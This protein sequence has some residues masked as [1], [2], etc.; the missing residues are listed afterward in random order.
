MSGAGKRYG[1]LQVFRDVEFAVGE[2]DVLT[3]IGPSGC[4]KTTLLR[5]I[6]GLIPL[7]QGEIT[8]EIEDDGVPFDPT[9][10]PAPTLAGSLIERRPG[11]LG[12]VSVRALTNSIEYRRASERNCLVLRRR[13]EGEDTAPQPSQTFSVSDFAHGGGRVIAIVGRLDSPVAKMVRDRL[14]QAI[15]DG[16]GRFAVDLSR[17]SYVSS[18]GIW[19]LLAAEYLASARGGGLVIFGL[20]REI[21]QLFERTG[22]LA[23]LRV[24]DT[25]EEALATLQPAAP[26]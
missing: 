22:I 16:P 26:L 24:C 23:A 10:V 18:A 8:V 15:H 17:V 25:A 5:C 6:D 11:G 14:L 7:T 2:R 4:G 9:Q 13:V 3:I 21:R 12:I 20:S 19:A 1:T